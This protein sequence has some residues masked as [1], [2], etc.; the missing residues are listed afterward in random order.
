M[1]SKKEIFISLLADPGCDKDLKDIAAELKVSSRTLQRWLSEP[2][3]LN[4][5][6]SRY[7]SVIG[8]RL[9]KVLKTLLAKAERG[10]VSSI[11]L[12]LLQTKVFQEEINKEEFLSTPKALELLDEFFNKRCEKCRK[13]NS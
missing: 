10:D 8:S 13:N 9:P 3:I 7:I 1:R 2:E 12:I 11:K 6:Y 4:K 5:A